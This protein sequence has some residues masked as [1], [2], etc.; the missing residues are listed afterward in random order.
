MKNL[1]NQKLEKEIKAI[2]SDASYFICYD[3][4]IMR[5]SDLSL[6]LNLDYS[7]NMTE[8]VQ[9]NGHANFQFAS[10]IEGLI[11]ETIPCHFSG[12]ATI[13]DCKVIEVDKPI[14]VQKDLL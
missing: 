7:K 1:L 9:F 14:P 13:S 2:I 3:R 8:E 4:T 11:S 5:L 12:R 6:N 10:P